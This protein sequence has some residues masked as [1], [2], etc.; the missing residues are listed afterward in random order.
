[1]VTHIAHID[2]IY[3]QIVSNRPLLVEIT[4][5]FLFTWTRRVYSVGAFGAV[6]Q[7]NDLGRSEVRQT[8]RSIKI[9][10]A[11]RS[12]VLKNCMWGVVAQW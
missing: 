3:S 8:A 4:Q 6:Q 2:Y 9:Y 10:N 5:F 12:I 11:K 1:M 7:I